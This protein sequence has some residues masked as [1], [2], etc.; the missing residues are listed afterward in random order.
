MP[1]EPPFT[2]PLLTHRRR[3]RAA[4]ALTLA[5]TLVAAL[6]LALTGSPAHAAGTLLSQGK[7]ATASSVEAVGT[8]ASAAVDGDTTSRWSS[9]FGDPQWLEVDL[10]A[11]ATV[12]Q[13]V[14]DWEAA[15]A[16]AFQIQTSPDGTTW[17]SIYSTDRKSV[18]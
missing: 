10:G 18:V 2:A 11:T 5:A 1:G 17:T 13:V 16:T 9:A 14:L 3:G 12:N 7:T 8:P 6:L 15:Y 4:L